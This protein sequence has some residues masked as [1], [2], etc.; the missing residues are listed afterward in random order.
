M[1]QPG[2]SNNI[3]VCG[4]RCV[5]T[6]TS[7]RCQLEAAQEKLVKSGPSK[8]RAPAKSG[9]SKSAKSGPSKSRAASKSGPSTSRAQANKASTKLLKNQ[10]MPVHSGD[11]GGCWCGKV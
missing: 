5:T 6:G 4:K 8:S 9:P 3:Q 11:G 2:I 7:D 1:A 10:E